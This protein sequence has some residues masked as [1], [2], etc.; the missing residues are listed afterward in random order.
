[1]A[2]DRTD[3][4]QKTHWLYLCGTLAGYAGESSKGIGMTDAIEKMTKAYG[5]PDR[6]LQTMDGEIDLYLHQGIL[7]H[8]DRDQRVSGWTLFAEKQQ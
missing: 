8:L 7:F 2:A 4:A 5:T 3:A 1:M 6:T